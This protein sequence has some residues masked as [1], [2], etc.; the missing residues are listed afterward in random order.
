[1]DARGR[2]VAAL[3]AYWT[4]I[5]LS[6]ALL[7]IVLGVWATGDGVLAR[8]VT[9]GLIRA[10]LVIGLYIFIGN[11][12][13]L[14][15]GHV[16]F[17]MVGAYATA[18][19]TMTPFKKS[20]ALQLPAILAEHQYP[21]LPS[22]IA[23]ASLAALVAFVVG[24]PIMRLSGIAAAIATLAVLGMFKTFYTNWSEWTL[25]AA[26]MPGLP[27][28][29]DM[30]V[31][32]AW[33]V[34]ALFAAYLYQQS[35]YGLALRATRED[36][37]AA[38]SVGINI[39]RQCL[40]AFVLSAFFMGIG[41]VLEAHFLGTIA[42]K[43]FWLAITFILLAMLIVGGQRSLTGAL[44]GVVVISTI[45]ELLN[46]LEAG[47]DV[48]IAV[49]S[50]PIGAQ[51]LTV[52]AVMILIL[53]LR[54]AGI[55]GGREI[56]WPFAGP[57]TASP[58]DAKERPDPGSIAVGAPEDTLETIDVAVHFEG[59]AAIDGVSISIKHREVLGLIGPNGAGKTTLVN[60]LTGFQRPSR[61]RVVLGGDDITGL[62]PHKLGR[63]GLERTFQA[64]RLFRDLPVIENLEVA[65]VG[66]GLGRREASRRA[67]GILRWMNFERR[68]FDRADT[69][70][71]GEERRVG[72]GRA[73]ATAPRF[74]L[75]DEPAAGLSDAE[76]DELM[77]LIS[78]IP[79]EFGCGVL[80]IEHNM[81]VVMGACD[82]IHVIDTG[83]TIAEGTPEEIQ[84]NPDVI[85]AY[86]GSKSERDSA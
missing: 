45:I 21:M 11:S 10:V 69:L 36:Q 32:L 24:V 57:R 27:I 55:A 60:V 37:F 40:I 66:T 19:L 63:R 78:R 13:V 39:P 26:T 65:A 83:K 76:C 16:T 18:W 15:F 31:G 59:L 43:N 5:S 41:G 52:A 64:V 62:A 33:A 49:I 28:Y 71:Y 74:V 50:V 25:G 20:F 58:P 14:A 81:R 54:P 46:R 29:V 9:D 70:P 12:G 86:L 42:V 80:L 67:W 8:T 61:G 77:G 1:M 23:A 2:L 6:L 53:V 34:V 72:I 85:R 17:M 56:P 68:A 48:G 7:L 84:A 35:K 82:R 38:R 51:E 22:A 4:P 79:D 30:W 3:R 73:L 47:I 44:L 75:L